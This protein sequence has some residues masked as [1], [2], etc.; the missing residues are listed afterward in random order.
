MSAR[1]SLAIIVNL[2][3]SA[4]NLSDVGTQDRILVTHRDARRRCL[5]DEAIGERRRALSLGNVSV[6]LT[7]PAPG[8]GCADSRSAAP[9]RV[10]ARADV[11][12]Q[13]ASRTDTVSAQRS[14]DFVAREVLRSWN[15][16]L[17]APVSTE[18]NMH[19]GRLVMTNK[20][21]SMRPAPGTDS[22]DLSIRLQYCASM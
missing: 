17:A 22:P 13:W 10:G 4:E 21:L 15:H 12:F 3:C 8:V 14:V 18:I 5:R 19:G 9:D 20:G 2:D 6:H 1:R 11:G 16:V 7:I